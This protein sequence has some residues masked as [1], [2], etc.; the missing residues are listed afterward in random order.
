MSEEKTPSGTM[1][2]D[3]NNSRKQAMRYYDSL[4]SRLNYAVI[5][6]DDVYGRPNGATHDY[7]NLKGYVLIDSD[8]IREVLDDLRSVIGGIAMTYQQ[9]EEDFK[10]VF[11]EVY[12]K[13]EDGM[14][15]F[16]DPEIEEEEK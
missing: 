7:V 8:E 13:E 16:Y 11:S 4:V 5:K 14:K 6:K 10:D 9:G 1:K 15:I 2:V 12:P 3:F